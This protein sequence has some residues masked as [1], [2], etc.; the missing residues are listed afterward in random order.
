MIDKFFNLPLAQV[1]FYLTV[2]V[3]VVTFIKPILLVIALSVLVYSLYKIAFR[4]R[5]DSGSS[6]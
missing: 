1:L 4:K 5:I 3:I 6:L 2:L